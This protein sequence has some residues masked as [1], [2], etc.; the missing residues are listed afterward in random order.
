MP[1][2]TMRR[3][4]RNGMPVHDQLRKHMYVYHCNRVYLQRAGLVKHLSEESL[5]SR[6]SGNL[7]IVHYTVIAPHLLPLPHSLLHPPKR[8]SH[9][10]PSKQRTHP[11]SLRPCRNSTPSL[12]GSARPRP[13][14][15]PSRDS[16]PSGW[17]TE[18]SLPASSLV[19]RTPRAGM[20]L[21][22]TAKDG[23]DEERLCGC[24]VSRVPKRADLG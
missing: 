10:P 8:P 20:L 19:R 14:P 12:S 3:V 7:D 21:R 11:K 6:V 5:T 2:A 23:T 15:A 1:A 16:P 18:C 9:T 4:D 17:Q 13:P 22:A 24:R